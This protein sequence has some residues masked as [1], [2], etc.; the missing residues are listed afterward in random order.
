MI[1]FH[2]QFKKIIKNLPEDILCW[3]NLSKNILDKYIEEEVDEEEK[4][5]IRQKLMRIKENLLGYLEMYDIKNVEGYWKIKIK[6]KYVFIILK[7]RDIATKG[8]L[9]I[10]FDIENNEIF[11]TPNFDELKLIL[12]FEERNINNYLNFIEGIIAEKDFTNAHHLELVK[13]SNIA[14]DLIE[15]KTFPSSHEVTKNISTLIN[16]PEDLSANIKYYGLN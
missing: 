13:Y 7:L 5:I 3:Y 8:S 10:L 6:M 12:D 4:K 2:I 11:I 1:N 16:A 9:P 15:N 14:V